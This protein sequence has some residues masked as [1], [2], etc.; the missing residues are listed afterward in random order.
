MSYE[1]NTGLGVSNHY[2]P[3]KVAGVK[4]DLPGDGVY[5]DLVVNL[6]GTGPTILFPVTNGTA[7]YIGCDTTYVT[8][9]V[10]DL[11]IGAVD[12][13]PSSSTPVQ[14]PDGNTGV[15]TVTGGTAGN[16][17]IHYKVFV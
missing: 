16:L 3:R 1:S 7:Y 8:G 14:I 11:D 5:K 10:T 13:D 2:G 12:L 6:D 4:G 9:T 15:I 17:I